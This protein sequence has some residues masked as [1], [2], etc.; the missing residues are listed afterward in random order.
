M[1]KTMSKI[2]QINKEELSAQKVELALADDIE[3]TYNKIKADADALNS[4]VRRAAQDV[5]EVSDKAKVLV[6]RIDDTDT[7][8]KKLVQA[9]N[10]LGVDIPSGAK[11]AVSQLQAY[12]NEL[13]ELQTRAERASDGLFALLG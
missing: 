5:D 10:D 3:K 7:D 13:S 11:V 9:A 8:V 1:K 4:T 6:K 12:R 2:A